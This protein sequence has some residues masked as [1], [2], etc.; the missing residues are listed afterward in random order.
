VSASLTYCA[1]CEDSG[2]YSLENIMR[3]PGWW[4][5][6]AT[7]AAEAKREERWGVVEVDP[8]RQ[9][10]SGRALLPAAERARHA[11]EAERALCGLRELAA[12][13]QRQRS[14]GTILDLCTASTSGSSAATPAVAS[15]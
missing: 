4:P 14:S 12:A 2:Y 13:Q 15:P 11:A 1:T 10:V 9:Q 3:H 5:P 7:A 6:M 8:L